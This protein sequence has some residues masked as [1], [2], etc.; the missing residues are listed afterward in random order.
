MPLVTARGTFNGRELCDLTVLNAGGRFGKT[1][2][3]E[4]TDWFCPLFLVV[5]GDSVADAIDDLASHPLFAHHVVVPE[6]DLGDY[7]EEDRHYG[8]NGQVL[9]LD[10][11]MIHGTEA[12]DQPW[13]CTYHGEGMLPEG[14]RPSEVRE[15]WDQR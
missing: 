4:I 8:P 11:L 15:W 1:W 7:P 12:A 10:H 13:A 9:D 14:I 6:A 3:L 5:E 2:L